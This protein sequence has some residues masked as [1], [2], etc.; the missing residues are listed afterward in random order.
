MFLGKHLLV[1]L[2]TA[3]NGTLD[4]FGVVTRG[5]SDECV[6]MTVFPDNSA[7]FT[8][9]SVPVVSD[10]DAANARRESGHTGPIAYHPPRP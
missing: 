4:A 2:A 8:T 5:W 9:C 3:S 7:P 10:L 6:N 1:L